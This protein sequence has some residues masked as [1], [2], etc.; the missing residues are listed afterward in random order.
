MQTPKHQGGPL[1]TPDPAPASMKDPTW[2]PD[3]YE[4]PRMDEALAREIDIVWTE[5]IAHLDYVRQSAV[6]AHTRKGHTRC[7]AWHEGRTVGYGVLDP[8][9]KR[10]WPLG[11]L[12]RVFWVKPHDRSEQP[13]GIYAHDCPAEAVDPRTVAPAVEGYVTV[14]ARGCATSGKDTQ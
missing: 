5:D 6:I 12:R 4:D 11:F 3:M 2:D 8:S 10:D 9:T 13:D 7:P 14:R 1:E